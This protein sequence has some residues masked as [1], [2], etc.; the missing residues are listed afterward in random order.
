MN[1]SPRRV[2]RRPAI[3]RSRDPA[4]R[5]ASRV[6]DPRVVVPPST[7]AM[8]SRVAV[9]VASRRARDGCAT[10]TLHTRASCRRR[11]NATKTIRDARG[12]STHTRVC[13]SRARSRDR[14]ARANLASRRSIDF[15]GSNIARMRGNRPRGDLYRASPARARPTSRDRSR[16]ATS[17]RIARAPDGLPTTVREDDARRARPRSNAIERGRAK[18]ARGDDDD[19]DAAGDAGGCG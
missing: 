17:D 12:R 8:K 9:A 5:V 16:R 3:P 14:I 2:V 18:D 4:I 6:V 15:M 13:E 11:S 10:A 19:G 7:R 1:R